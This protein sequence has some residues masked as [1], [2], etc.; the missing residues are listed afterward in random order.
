[1]EP[2]KHTVTINMT[3]PPPPMPVAIQAALAYFMACRN[4]G[5]IMQRATQCPNCGAWCR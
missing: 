5:A 2:I 3:P 4:C 1:M